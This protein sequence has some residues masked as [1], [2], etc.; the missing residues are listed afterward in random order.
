M[1]PLRVKRRELGA[2]SGSSGCG[3]A[4]ATSAASLDAAAPAGRTTSSTA[5]SLAGAEAPSTRLVPSPPPVSGMRPSSHP[6]PEAGPSPAAVGGAAATTAPPPSVKLSSEL[7]DAAVEAYLEY[8]TRPH[9]SWGSASRFQAHRRELI[10]E[11]RQSVYARSVALS[12]RSS[13]AST[14]R[15]VGDQDALEASTTSSVAS[16][17]AGFPRTAANGSKTS[18]GMLR[19][20]RLADVGTPLP[21]SQASEP[22]TVEPRS[23]SVTT[24][25]IS[26]SCSTNAASRTPTGAGQRA[27]SNKGRLWRGAALAGPP[28][29]R[30]RRA[31]S[32]TSATAAALPG[33]VGLSVGGTQLHAGNSSLFP[34]SGPA[35]A[36]S[37]RTASRDGTAIPPPEVPQSGGRGVVA[38]MKVVGGRTVA[39]PS[40]LKQRLT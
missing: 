33:P 18:T 1:R 17:P 10:E 9:T 39:P 23:F 30:Q 5:S 34:V 20:G 31:S 38:P 13:F 35:T 24:A 14:A 29:Q 37:H 3:A 21:L 8:L 12:R 36:A 4:S 6:A 22:F 27:P 26:S 19:K 28:R 25:S 7:D 15:S 16:A 2:A 32:S 11:H 40:R